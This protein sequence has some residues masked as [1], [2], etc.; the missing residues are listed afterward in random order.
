MS[1]DLV[2]GDDG[3][4]HSER[5]NR[6]RHYLKW[7]AS[8]G[9]HDQ[10][11]LPPPEILVL[12]KLSSFLQ[13]WTKVDDRNVATTITEHP[14]PDINELNEAIPKAEWPVGRKGEKEPPFKHYCGFKLVNPVAGTQYFY[15][16]STAGA[17]LLYDDM[18]ESVS[19]VRALRGDR[20]FPVVKL[21]Q[22]S[23]TSKKWG[24]V[25]RPHFEILQW[26][27]LGGGNGGDQVPAPA[28]APQLTGP[29]LE[30][31]PEVKPEPTA[32]STSTQPRQPKKPITVSAYTQAVMGALPDAK[33]VTTEELLDDSL[34]NLPW[35][36]Q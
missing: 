10:D 21:G 23:W 34:E 26:K 13:R 6:P 33:P 16:N 7:T 17:Q 27:V 12:V 24:S 30:P 3:F 11:G 19:T 8:E 4:G 36:N 22:T 5:P 29:V 14:L 2:G 25:L 15:A 18:D 31:T 35:D 9:W 1:N 32:T 20:C 28:P